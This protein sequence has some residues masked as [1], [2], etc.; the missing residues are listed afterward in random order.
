[1][2]AKKLSLYLEKRPT[3][4]PLQTAEKFEVIWYQNSDPAGMAFKQ[5]IVI[6]VLVLLLLLTNLKKIFF[7]L[8]EYVHRSWGS[9]WIPN[10]N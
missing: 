10:M 8:R 2:K 9:F 5:V 1:M 3:S 7:F 6:N 4:L